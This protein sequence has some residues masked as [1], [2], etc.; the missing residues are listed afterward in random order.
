M[1]LAQLT[2]YGL[3]SPVASVDPSNAPD[4]RRAKADAFSYTY[5]HV[6]CILMLG[7]AVLRKGLQLYQLVVWPHAFAKC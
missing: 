5:D 1:S 6:R 7:I 4:Q 3:S 2:G